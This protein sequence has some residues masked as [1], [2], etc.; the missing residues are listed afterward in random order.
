MFLNGEEIVT[1]GEHGQRIVDDS[2]VLLFNAG[3]EDA[4]LTLPPA[5]FGAQW[6]CELRTD[7][8]D[9]GG[10]YGPG[11]PVALAVALA[12]APAPHVLM[13]ELL[14]TYRLQL[15]GGFGF[16]Q[17]R[18]LVPYLR[19]LGVSHLYLPPSFQAREGSTHG[20]D[21][22]DPT[23]I[24][25]ELGGEPRRSRRSPPRCARPGWG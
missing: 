16:A 21:V 3:H 12:R 11:E 22:V 2:F 17:A 14:A 1:P 8:E 15:G 20:Y 4:E 24:S 10:T 25:K 7:G 9:C 5:R 19:D 6:T 13:T 18:E 23:S